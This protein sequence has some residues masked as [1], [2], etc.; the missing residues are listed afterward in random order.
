MV[1]MIGRYFS[2]VVDAK[3][4]TTRAFIKMCTAYAYLV[5]QGVWKF[6]PEFKTANYRGFSKDKKFE[7][8]RMVDR[9]EAE[10]QVHEELLTIYTTLAEVRFTLYG[11][12]S[13]HFPFLMY[14]L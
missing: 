12:I 2:T 14:F 9:T 13:C 7:I 4:C 3:E 8:Q 11:A 6:P 1:D 5:V 10:E